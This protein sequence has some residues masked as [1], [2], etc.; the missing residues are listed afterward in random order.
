MVKFTKQE[1]PYLNSGK[2]VPSSTYGRR[3]R[4][5]LARWATTYSP[6]G[7][8]S[9]LQDVSH[10]PVHAGV[11]VAWPYPVLSVSLA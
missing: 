10:L 1:L 2:F 5:V 11:D 9:R 7:S 8:P 3:A 6:T 4:P